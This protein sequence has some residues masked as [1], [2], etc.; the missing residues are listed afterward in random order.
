MNVDLQ[1]YFL[2]LALSTIGTHI[3]IRKKSHINGDE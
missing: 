2:M 3:W 1:V